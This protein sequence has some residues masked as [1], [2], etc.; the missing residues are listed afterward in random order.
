MS[1]TKAQQIVN[2][3]YL[4]DC[5]EQL[6]E[7]YKP[8]GDDLKIENLQLSYNSAIAQFEQLTKSR[9]EYQQVVNL[10]KIEFLK[11]NRKTT[12]VLKTITSLNVCQLTINNLQQT[13][14]RIKGYALSAITNDSPRR[15]QQLSYDARLNNLILYIEQIE[16]IETYKTNNPELAPQSLRQYATNL[17]KVSDNVNRKLFTIKLLQLDRD[18]ALYDTQNGIVP[19]ARRAKAYIS[20]LYQADDAPFQRLLNFN[21]QEA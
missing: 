7:N 9:S 8:A 12:H 19:L 10:R 18:K 20:T 4:L 21:F 15:T 2:F 17:Q 11:L 6:G 1:K 14:R 5:I 13:A 3:R 16:K